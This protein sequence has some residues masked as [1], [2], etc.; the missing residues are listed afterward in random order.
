[1]EPTLMAFVDWHFTWCETVAV[2]FM[3]GPRHKQSYPSQIKHPGKVAKRL[4]IVS[5][6]TPRERMLRFRRLCL[7]GRMMRA[8]A[9]DNYLP[10]AAA[11]CLQM[12][13]AGW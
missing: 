6:A 5:S 11:V 4:E 12:T 1:M 2:W 9:S 8:T 3:L 10:C 13:G 7:C